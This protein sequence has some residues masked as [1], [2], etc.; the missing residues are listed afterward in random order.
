MIQEG[1]TVQGKM[2]ASGAL[3]DGA[4][5]EHARHQRCTG[6]MS[7]S[8][9]LRGQWQCGGASATRKHCK[10]DMTVLQGRHSDSA[11]TPQRQG[12]GCV[13]TTKA[14]QQ[15]STQRHASGSR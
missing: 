7:G 2:R 10:G 5:R 12:R 4:G 9:V 14:A 3:G 15:G 11:R 6:Q 1:N 8:K 13:G